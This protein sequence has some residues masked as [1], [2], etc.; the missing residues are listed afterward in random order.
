MS[1]PRVG[2]PTVDPNLIAQQAKAERDRL[3]AEEARRAEEEAKRAQAAG[4]EQAYQDKPGSLDRD[5]VAKADP[6][7]MGGYEKYAQADGSIKEEDFEKLFAEVHGSGATAGVPQAQQVV[8]PDSGRVSTRN[9]LVGYANE[10]DNKRAALQAIEQRKD[11]ELRAM[12]ETLTPDQQ[13]AFKQRWDEVHKSEIDHANQEIDKAEKNLAELIQGQAKEIVAAY[14]TGPNGPFQADINRALEIAAS[15]KDTPSAA[16]CAELA[17]ET[18][19]DI[20]KDPLAVANAS[21]Q[22]LEKLQA[23]GLESINT[24]MAEKGK[25]LAEQGKSQEEIN[26]AISGLATRAADQLEA[27][28]GIALQAVAGGAEV[29]KE[30]KEA[31]N[32]GFQTSRGVKELA[33]DVANGTLTADKVKK[34]FEA[35][36]DLH[37]PKVSHITGA[38]AAFGVVAAGLGAA[39]AMKD[40]DWAAALGQMKDGGVDIFEAGKYG[41]ELA[42]HWATV[43]QKGEKLVE[44]AA[45]VG[46]A[47]ERCSFAASAVVGVINTVGDFAAYAKDHQNG[48]LLSALGDGMTAAGGVLALMGVPAGPIMIGAGAAISFAGGKIAEKQKWDDWHGDVEKVLTSLDQVTLPNGQKVPSL[49]NQVAGYL[50][51]LQDGGEQAKLFTEKMGLSPEQVQQLVSNHDLADKLKIGITQTSNENLAALAKLVSENFR[52]P[53]GSLDGNAAFQ[54]IADLTDKHQ[55]RVTSN[56]PFHNPFEENRELEGFFTT[57]R[58]GGFDPAKPEGDGGD[59]NTY[60]FIRKHLEAFRAAQQT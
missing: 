28:T 60:E 39:A 48:H 50:G 13:A 42:K 54:F 44:N 56:S 34:V 29:N 12:G 9:E 21:A 11:D 55:L 41:A 45:R 16:R 8:E 7:L 26:K 1:D 51:T 53:N 38:L 14:Q 19:Q 40:G 59:V 6:D 5:T 47:L 27:A 25:E 35:G 52:R 43:A 23:I 4:Q 10:V 57:I 18:V 3:A 33:V 22:D 58:R 17:R 24:E 46:E 15:G 37:S 32:A 31:L 49:G 30:K 20:L 36:Q 2:G